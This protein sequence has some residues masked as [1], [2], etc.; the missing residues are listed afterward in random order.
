MSDNEATYSI[1]L[2]GDAATVSKSVAEALEEMR[3]KAN[4]AEEAIK[5]G[6]K[7]LRAMRGSSDEV[8]EA[9]AK[10][11]A[12]LDAE[13]MA[14]SNANLEI[15]KQG[16]SL[17]ALNRATDA[18]KAKHEGLNQGLLKLLGVSREARMKISELGSGF[19]SAELA[20]AGLVAGSLALVGALAAITYGAA[21]A[22]VSLGRFIL[23]G[24]DANR[25][26]ALSR[27]WIAGSA[28]DSARMGDQIDRIRQKVPLTTEELSKL[29]VKTRAGFDGARVSGEAIKNTVE[30]LAQA[31]GA[32]ADAAASKIDQILSRGK[33]AGR[34]GINGPNAS[35]PT[36]ELAG[37]G[38]KFGDV[39]QA[40]ADEMHVSLAKAEGM[41]R[42]YRVPIEAGAA[43]LRKASEKA[44]GDIN[45]EK[46]TTAD[47]L[48][49]KWGDDLKNLTRGL[50][51]SA[52]WKGIARIENVFSTSTTSGYALKQIVGTIGKQLGL[53][54]TKEAPIVE[55]ALRLVILQ[56]SKMR[57]M[58]LQAAI[59][60]KEA[61]KGDLLVEKLKT[62][63]ETAK[64]VY[65][66]MS[67]IVEVAGKVSEYSYSTVAPQDAAQEQAAKYLANANPLNSVVSAA[68]AAFNYGKG[69]VSSKT[70]TAPAHAAGGLV[71][72]P[73][74]GEAFASVAPGERI[75]PRGGDTRRSGGVSLQVQLTVQV[76]AASAAGKD[77]AQAIKSSS[78][79]EDFA[80]ALQ[81]ALQGAGVPIL[82]DP[83]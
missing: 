60:W 48:T 46:M 74:P 9:K 76:N 21:S 34:I 19:S 52:L 73:A 7:A 24:A 44:F 5:N 69:E 6:S 64:S 81:D 22:A 51:L 75:I 37:S 82:P 41:L 71:M 29:Y 80:S 10:L 79:L 62:A 32:G 1:N 58:F 83:S 14:F 26:L 56:A 43:A 39:G 27:Q 23:V 33:L 28:E 25:S 49:K 78:L 40:L 68:G 54:G 12:S 57:V 15:L 61:G 55:T 38:L 11:K 2:G 53:V 18:S 72:Q 42:S 77:V 16:A 50:D 3:Q 65:D 17:N 35:N 4:A 8:K 30:A 13:K 45:L 31:T 59:A 67:K 36:G 66:V 20:S 63:Y 47:A 70:V